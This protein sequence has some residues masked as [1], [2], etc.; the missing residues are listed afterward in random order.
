VLPTSFSQNSIS[1]TR[2]GLTLCGATFSRG[3]LL[4]HVSFGLT[5]C[6]QQ[7]A[8]TDSV[9]SAGTKGITVVLLQELQKCL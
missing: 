3:N 4:N 5:H 8:L 9:P 2:K 7:N 6:P 1:G